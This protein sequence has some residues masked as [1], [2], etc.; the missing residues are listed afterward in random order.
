MTI[1]PRLAALALLVVAATDL[2]VVVSGR[3]HGTAVPASWL[4]EHG[5]LLLYGADIGENT[6][7]APQ[8]AVMKG[9]RLLPDR[10]Y[11]GRP[12]R[13]VS[14]PPATSSPA[15]APMGP[16]RRTIGPVWRGPAAPSP[17]RCGW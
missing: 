3:S 2:L 6:Y 8:S 7:V 17:R 5:A 14:A 10:V 11:A 9:E 15:T 4:A 12:T 16:S 13:P 1:R